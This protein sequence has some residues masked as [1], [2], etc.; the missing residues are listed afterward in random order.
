MHSLITVDNR[1]T[2]GGG[3][4]GLSVTRLL[5]I[6]RI[7]SD[8]QIGRVARD[9]QPIL[10]GR[11]PNRRHVVMCTD[12]LV[13][14]IDFRRKE[15]YGGGDVYKDSMDCYTNSDGLVVFRDIPKSFF[16]EFG[17]KQ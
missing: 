9:C 12:T 17:P 5:P 1:P 10:A 8:D 3:S 11:I 16:R 4:L 7:T 6:I 2:M 14:F 15:Y 13:K